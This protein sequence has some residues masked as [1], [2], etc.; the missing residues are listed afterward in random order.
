ME[1]WY[2]IYIILVKRIPPFIPVRKKRG[3][4]HRKDPSS[5][6]E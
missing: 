5:T 3:E 2:V 4:A 6:Q 1:T